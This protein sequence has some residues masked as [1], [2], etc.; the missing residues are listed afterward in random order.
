MAL[1]NNISIFFHFWHRICQKK[2]EKWQPNGPLYA[3]IY[4]YLHTY[5]LTYLHTYILISTYL[6]LYHIYTSTP[7]YLH[8]HLPTHLH[9]Y[10]L[11]HIFILFF[12]HTTFILVF[13]T[14]LMASN[15]QIQININNDT[16]NFCA[17]HLALA[18]TQTNLSK[19]TSW[20]YLCIYKEW[21]VCKISNIQ[22]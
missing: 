17:Q 9:T 6:P 2:K 10:I 12:N 19:N 5:T 16:A 14:I 8:L 11:T 1:T 13:Y 18:L 7:T 22:Y 4:T 20:A 3:Y 21:K 15:K